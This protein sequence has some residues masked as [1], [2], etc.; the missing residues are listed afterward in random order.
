MKKAY[1]KTALILFILAVLVVPSYSFASTIRTDKSANVEQVEKLTGNI[2]LAGGYPKVL[3]EVNGDVVVAGNN[4]DILGNV[5]GDVVVVG[6]NLNIKGNI[7]GDVRVVGGVVSV[8][9]SISGDLVVIGSEIKI[10]KNAKIEGDLILI[11]A[12]VNLE[13]N[14][15]THVRIISGTTIISGS[16]LGTANI[17]SEK[18]ILRQAQDEASESRNGCDACAGLKLQ[19]GT[20]FAVR[21]G[22]RRSSG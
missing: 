12:S 2:Y 11:G 1:L 7:K 16:V 21:P 22:S 9:N 14:S 18:I 19:G 17:T 8:E 6:G 4:V 15:N 10:L 5:N 20:R 13:N 3:G